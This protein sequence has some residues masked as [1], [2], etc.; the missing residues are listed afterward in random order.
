VE[1]KKQ[2]EAKLQQQQKDRLTDIVKAAP[3]LSKWLNSLGLEEY[4][5]VFV[6]N[7]YDTMD[8]IGLLEEKDLDHMAITLPGHRKKLLHA[9]SLAKPEKVTCRSSI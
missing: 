1:E 7:G 9:A 2:L 4:M 5:E 3:E 8:L 6:R